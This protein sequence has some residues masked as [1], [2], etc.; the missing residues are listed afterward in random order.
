MMM[1]YNRAGSI[2]HIRQADGA[3]HWA[4]DE[5][6]GCHMSYGTSIVHTPAAYIYLYTNLTTVI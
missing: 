3:V 5:C 4:S 6:A 2:V 1:T